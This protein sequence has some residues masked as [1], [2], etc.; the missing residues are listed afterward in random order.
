MTMAAD[1]A[2]GLD[3]GASLQGADLFG[4]LSESAR[5]EI[6][7]H[8]QPLALGDGETVLRQ[9]E[10]GDRLYLVLAGA[11]EVT[12]V[13]RRGS[14]RALPDL[15]PGR[16]VGESGLLSAA[17]VS[18]TARAR[19]PALVATLSRDAFDRFA[20]RCPAGGIELVEALRPLLRRHRMWVA[21]H[22]SD[23]FRDLDEGVLADL[24]SEV[25]L[26]AL[27]GGEVLFR[28]GDP[29]DHL[30]VV[31][32]GRLR[33]VSDEAGGAERV[34]AELGVGETIGEMAII[35]G[36][37]RS[38]AVYA[39]RDTELARISRAGVER[40]LERHPR[41]MLTMLTGRLVERLRAQGGAG[42]RRQGPALA[43]IALVGAAPEVP[44][45]TFGARLC[46]ALA[47]LGSSVL[48]SSGTVDARLGRQGAA[49]ALDRDGGG[50]RLVEWLAEQEL[51]HQVVVYQA[52]AGLSPWTERAI[53]QAD[54]VVIV[55]EA[56]GPAAPGEIESELLGGGRGRRV[57]QTLALLHAPGET[58][59]GTARWLAG[60][61]L[62]RHLHMRLEDTR[63]FGRLA[64]FLAGGAVGL[65]LG[66]GFAR[67]L[68]HLGVVRA[69]GERQVPIDAIGGSSMGA[70]V[71][72]LLVLGWEGDRIAREV[73]AGL[74]DSFDDMT[75]PF[76]A[77]KRGGKYSRLVRG[78][79][80]DTRIEDMWIPYFCVSA[81]LNRAELSVHAA[82]PLAD[83]VLASTRAPGIF[84]PVVVD[85]E[86]HVDGGV[87]NNVPVDVMRA[88]SNDGVVIGVDV[89]PPHELNHI[90]DYGE[91]VSGWRA[92][93]QRFNP[94]RHRR[95][96]RPSLLL[97]LMRVLEF[98]GIA[99][100]RQKADLADLYISPDVLRFKRNDFHA[101][102]HIVEAGYAAARE[103]I[104][105]WAAGQQGA[106]RAGAAGEGLAGIRSSDLPEVRP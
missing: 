12:F 66:G 32:S 88:F 87:I 38:A 5:R 61:R 43:T 104:E 34:V 50:T 20:E 98:G 101:A 57:P 52:D 15:G 80:G 62:D 81:N 55:A 76:L 45:G 17:P 72:A 82:G 60:R 13:D 59:S 28:R 18:L 85:G 84:P 68:A 95:V 77:F 22:L 14:V 93:W 67:G 27:Y 91:D 63:D 71:G 31:V 99:Y 7:R 9:G 47:P 35:S 51:D 89:S 25:E 100:R 40:V 6:A 49:Q 79:F 26:T 23:A 21:L 46:E 90:A 3:L 94:K 78:F 39:I 69:L 83:A 56:S 33:V 36:E 75:I 30:Y 48:L 10:C 106:R 16:V 73:S 41:A 92:I 64:R 42:R 96:Y 65:A 105:R 19:G 54:H 37:P 2:G 58:P 8:L 103:A 1:P 74:A 70:M 86:L 44:L 97:V 29:G 11:L 102:P 24:E 4:A 53:R